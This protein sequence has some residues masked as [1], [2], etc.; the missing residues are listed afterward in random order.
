MIIVIDT[1]ILVSACMG[2]PAA[3][4]VIACCLRKEH[5]PLMGTTLF[6]EYIDVINRDELFDRC[7]LNNDERNELLD[8]FLASCRWTEIYYG[9]R[10]NLRDEGDNHLIELAVAGHA[11]CV[12]SRNIKDL[13]KGELLF[14]GIAIVTPEQFLLRG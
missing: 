2:S 14:P 7:R 13:V 4:E 11:Q 3:N 6:S 8:I 12:V 9:W 1:N 10:P 5:Q